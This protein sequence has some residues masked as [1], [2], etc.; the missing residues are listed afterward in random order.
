MSNLLRHKSGNA[1]C[2]NCHGRLFRLVLDESRNV[3]EFV[4]ARATCGT[5]FKP[6]RFTPVEVK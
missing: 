4:C 6:V 1:K 3:I 2:E 5:I